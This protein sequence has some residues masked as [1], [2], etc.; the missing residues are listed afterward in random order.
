MEKIIVDHLILTFIIL[1]WIAEEMKKLYSIVVETKILADATINR[2]LLLN[3][4]VLETPLDYLKNLEE[5]F[6][7]PLL[8]LVD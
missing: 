1:I 6:K 2:M 8:N 4:M 5:V 3:A 7:L